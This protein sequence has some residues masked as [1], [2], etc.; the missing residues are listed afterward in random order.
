MFPCSSYS[1]VVEESTNR[2]IKLYRD[3]PFPEA[4]ILT[5]ILFLEYPSRSGYTIKAFST[6]NPLRYLSG[7]PN[8]AEV[9]KELY[10]GISSDYFEYIKK[11]LAG[12][13]ELPAR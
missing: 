5:R 12:D 10:G 2:L 11:Y 3:V 13:L 8:I 1:A 9:K 4:G 6:E 7:H